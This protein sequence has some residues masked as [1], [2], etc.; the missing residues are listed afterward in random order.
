MPTYYEILEVSRE[1][2]LEEIKTAYRRLA[3]KYHPDKN[4]GDRAAEERFKQISE[5]YQVLADPEKR[6]LFDL[7][8]DAGLAG[9]D[10][11]AFSGFEDIFNSF[12]E[13]FGDFFSPGRPRSGG[14]SPNPV[15]TCGSRWC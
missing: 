12:G 3:L 7:Y 5:A 15:R 6:Q 4:L 1:S 9:L 14:I 2:S 11:D 10:L 8:G 13:V